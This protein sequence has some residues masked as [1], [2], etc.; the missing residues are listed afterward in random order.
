MK[1]SYVSHVPE[2]HS[3][4]CIQF[5]AAYSEKA[6][7]GGLRNEPFSYIIAKRSEAYN[8]DI[9]AQNLS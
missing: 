7:S 2:V 1:Q 5:C 4:Y 8:R 3:L 9:R 6:I